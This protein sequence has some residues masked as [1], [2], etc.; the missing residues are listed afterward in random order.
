MCNWISSRIGYIGF[1]FFRLGGA[2]RLRQEIFYLA[3]H[4]HWPW[5]EI[6]ALAIADR[7][8]YVQM[9]SQRI[10]DDNQALEEL[11]QQLMKS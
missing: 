4:L 5:S 3:Y 1:F 8:V 10:E 11:N 2:Q 6:L 7:Q 9:L